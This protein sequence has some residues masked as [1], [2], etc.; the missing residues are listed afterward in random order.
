MPIVLNFNF[1]LQTK[2]WIQRGMPRQRVTKSGKSCTPLVPTERNRFR[3]A[4]KEA[5]RRVCT[6][7]KLGTEQIG[8]TLTVPAPPENAQWAVKQTMRVL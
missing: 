1:L 5:E 8:P 3:V 7:D 6:T 4:W 2:V